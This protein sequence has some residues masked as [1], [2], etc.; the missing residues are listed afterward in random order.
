MAGNGA[1]EGEMYEAGKYF[2]AFWFPGNYYDLAMY[3][4]NKENLNFTDID[5]KL[6]LSKDYSSA[7]GSRNIKTWLSQQ[8]LVAEPP[9]TG[10]GCG[11]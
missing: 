8:G 4:K 7:S 5:A 3:F 10:G 11:V 2:N 6:L 1:S 9:K